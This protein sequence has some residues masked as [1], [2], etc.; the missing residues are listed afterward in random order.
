MAPIALLVSVAVLLLE[1]I[2]LPFK[3]LGAFFKAYNKEKD[4]RKIRVT[5]SVVQNNKGQITIKETRSY[6]E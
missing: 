6:K 4:D 5:R 2:S 3:I 1:L